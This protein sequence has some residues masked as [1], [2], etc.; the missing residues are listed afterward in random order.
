VAELIDVRTVLAA[1][2][3]ARVEIGEDGVLHVLAGPI[4]IHLERAVCEELTETLAKAMAVL[5]RRSAERPLLRIVR[6]HSEIETNP[7]TQTGD[8]S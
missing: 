1:S 2:R 3:N 4:T 8:R 7:E 5:S 6:R